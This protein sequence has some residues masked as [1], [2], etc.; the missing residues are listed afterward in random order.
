MN[1]YIRAYLPAALMVLPLSW[2]FSTLLNV[3]VWN[4][5]FGGFLALVFLAVRDVMKV[6]LARRGNR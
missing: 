2:A 1:R 5:V 4:G 6:L 3:S